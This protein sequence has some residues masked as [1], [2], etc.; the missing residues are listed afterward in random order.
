VDSDKA[1]EIA[2]E[3]GKKYAQEHPNM[4]VSYTLEADLKTNA[5]VWRV[6]WGTSAA[7]SD[8]SVLIDAQSG[9]YIR[10]LF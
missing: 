9:E 1:W 4:P 2:K 3:H 5:P 10:T 7:T 8:Y 6:M